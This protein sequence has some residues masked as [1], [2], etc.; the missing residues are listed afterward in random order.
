MVRNPVFAAWGLKKFRATVFNDIYLEV[1]FFSLVS[2]MV[3]LVSKHTSHSLAISNQMLTVLGTVLGLVISFR[4]TSAY[5]RFQDGRK[6]WSNIMVASR[7]IAMMLWIHVPASRED[8]KVIKEKQPLLASVIEKRTIIN[9]V[10][11]FSV[12]VKHFL[13]AEPGIYYADLYPLI[14][15]LPR[16]SILP[17]GIPTKD[18]LLPL[19]NGS[20]DDSSVLDNPGSTG[21]ASTRQG[22]SSATLHDTNGEKSELGALPHKASSKRRK[23]FDPER[24]LPVVAS[25]QPLQPARLPP[26][27]TFWDFFGFLRFL[28]PVVRSVR[29]HTTKD[30]TA[31]GRKKREMDVESSIPLEITLYLSSYLAWLLRTGL[32]QPAIATG[33]VNNISGLQDTFNNLERIRNTPLPFAYQAHLRISSWLY[34][35]F[36]PFQIETAFGYLTIP[37]TA[38][39]AFLYLGFLEIGQE[40][41]NPFEYDENDLD[42][43]QF[44][45]MIQ[46]NYTRSPLTPR[47]TRPLS[48]S[49]HGTNLSH[50]A[51]DAQP[52]RW[53]LMSNTT[54]TRMNLELDW[55]AF[56]GRC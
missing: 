55:T 17:P 54:T 9:L 38:F 37:A 21:V 6:M 1:M 35:F 24:V 23:T 47:L 16:Y 2:A 53:S 50:L 5:E 31:S 26:K 44:C 19:W 36:L 30:L 51:T 20:A 41:E 18:D 10:Q 56:V 39:A 45:L 48:Y 11:A 14:C 34:L 52:K 25:D 49:L 28:R 27:T 43:D 29:G 8:N 42:L 32:I 40:I 3:V 33:L 7:N 22:Q 13:R 46:R 4:T 12:S 15:F